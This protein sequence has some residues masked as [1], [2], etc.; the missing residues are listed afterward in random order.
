[1][2]TNKKRWT[3]NLAWW[4]TALGLILTACTVAGVAWAVL[5]EP[6]I[7]CRIDRKV[8][9]VKD[10][11]MYQNCLIMQRYSADE[12]AAADRMYTSIKR[13]QAQEK[14]ETK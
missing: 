8:D 5:A 11:V 7:D 14:G 6:R 1:M 3:D 13:A 2:A 4:Q 10:A 12:I 9:P